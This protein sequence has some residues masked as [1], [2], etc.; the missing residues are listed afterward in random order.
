MTATTYP[1]TQR[2]G[3]NG[4]PVP[5]ESPRSGTPTGPRLARRTTESA[6]D[7][8]YSNHAPANKGPHPAIADLPTPIPGGQKA[9]PLID[10]TKL[11]ILE[12]EAEKLRRIIDEK[13]AKKR[14]AVMEWDRMSR[15]TEAAAVRSQIAEEALRKSSADADYLGEG[16][17]AAF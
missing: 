1:R 7:T 5:D 2:F 11:D 3:P 15:E 4:Q 8:S 9:E 6:L 16:A 17:S 10:R 14:K 12:N 13:E